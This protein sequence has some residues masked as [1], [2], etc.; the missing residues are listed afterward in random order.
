MTFIAR[1]SRF[2]TERTRHISVTG[3]RTFVVLNVGLSAA[4]VI[5]VVVTTLFASLGADALVRLN[6]AS[7]SSYLLGLYLNRRGFS[8][9]AVAI[10]AAE[11]IIHQYFCVTYL[12]WAAGFQYYLF[13]LP[14]IAFF[15]AR[16]RFPTRGLILA[17]AA[18]AFMWLGWVAEQA[19]PR[20][21]QHTTTL[22]I[23]NR[24]NIAAVFGLLGFF[25][26]FYNRAADL[27]EA[28]V[29]EE[30]RKVL[31]LMN[32]ILPA[33]IAERLQ[34]KQEVIAD[35]FESVTVLFADMVGFTPLSARLPPEKLV[36]ML[37]TIF[38]DF[39]ALLDRHGLEKIKTIGD[40][41]MV[42]AGVP[43]PRKDH[44]V[45]V[46]AA[47]LEMQAAAKARSR[48]WGEAFEL[49]IGIHIGP[50]VAGVIGKRRFIYDL[51]G[52]TVNTAARMES[53]GIPGEIQ[54]SEDMWHEIHNDFDL[55]ERGVI[56]VKGKGPMRTWLLRGHAVGK[57]ASS[58]RIPAVVV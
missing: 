35:R 47:A 2:F 3:Y 27:A 44:A 39:D 57:Q 38:S 52:D 17:A 34:N 58:P 56:N 14:G 8:A 25:A 48:E 43:S 26:F 54:V 40:A 42:A 22:S 7:I 37:D 55:A 19:P 18:V 28:R 41:Y 50:L 45:A 49:R 33:Q 23:L 51:W 21:L 46:A 30:R 53:H 13:V 10:A 16:S 29:E 5:H 4:A 9:L 12:G 11:L 1:L 20:I 6:I 36:A 31:D 24:S 15:L 32:L